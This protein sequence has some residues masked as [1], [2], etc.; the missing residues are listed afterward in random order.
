MLPLHLHKYYR[1][2]RTGATSVGG[3]LCY[4]ELERREAGGRVTMRNLFFPGVLT[5]RI[6]VPGVLTLRIVV[7]GVLYL[8]KDRRSRPFN[9][10]RVSKQF[11]R[12]AYRFQLLC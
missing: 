7:P 4:V 12:F 10:N 3:A 11:W 6:V 1:K 8:T 9:T 2:K 5:L